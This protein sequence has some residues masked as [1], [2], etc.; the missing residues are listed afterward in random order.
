M[1]TPVIHRFPAK[2][3]PRIVLRGFHRIT[4]LLWVP[5]LLSRVKN[6]APR[7]GTIHY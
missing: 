2:E 7:P 4:W 1:R 6:A 3:N 5:A